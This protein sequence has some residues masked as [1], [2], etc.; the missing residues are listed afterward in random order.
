[1]TRITLFAVLLIVTAPLAALGQAESEAEPH[2]S[3]ATGRPIGRIISGSVVNYTGGGVGGA[4]VIV[5]ALDGASRIIAEVSTNETGDIEVALPD[6]TP[7][8][9]RV[10]IRKDGFSEWTQELDLS[11]E[12]E[13]PFIDATLEGAARLTGTVEIAASGKPVSGA[14][15]SCESGGKD[16]HTSTDADGRFVL[17]QLF[18]GAATITVHAEGF[19]VER[20]V[21]AIK[22]RQEKTRILLRPERLV[23]LTIATSDGNPAAEVAIE[24]LAEPG[25]QH[26]EAV[27]DSRGVARIK[28]VGPEARL[29]RL[30]LNGTRYVRMN[31]FQ[32]TIDVSPAN[33]AAEAGDNHDLEPVRK[34]L[35]VQLAASIRGKIVDTAGEPI[36][37]ARIAAGRRLL[38][39]MP[40]TFTLAD[41]TYELPSLPG[42]PNVLTFLHVDY[43]PQV[44]EIQLHTGQAATI[45]VRMD[46]GK[47]IAGIV[48][49]AK[50]KPTEH[51][52][53]AVDRWKGY[54]KLGMR[55]ITDQEG[56]FAF[57][58]APEGELLLT[59]TDPAT[60]TSVEKT[61]VAGSTNEKIKLEAP[62]VADG[63]TDAAPA[64]RARVP[65]GRQVP[66]L[67][68][69]ATDGTKYK[70]ADL[71]GKF[72]FID[73]W[74]SWCGPCVGEIPN[75]KRLYEATRGRPDFLLIGISL[76][77]DRKA[78]DNAVS[79][80]KMKWPQVFG[81]DSGADEAFDALEGTAIPYTCLIGPDGR[82]IAQHLRGEKLSDEVLKHLAAQAGQ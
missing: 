79:D 1:M 2:E 32:E 53:V 56:R 29:L 37:G 21:V 28:G 51:V 68:M 69:T 35:V 74:A 60:G 41:G 38:Y 33:Q 34:R 62:T 75:I 17:D 9:V 40:M 43:A 67:V 63:G 3:A 27:T 48:V 72:I 52:R 36:S 64:P 77:R 76:D 47:Q 82:M 15:V 18:E 49:G 61:I 50:D 24:A 42:G 4:K 39:G 54:E 46:A 14:E 73:C 20:A 12:S 22:Y 30:R 16:S 7:G 80:F 11:D 66:D 26:F 31:D 55:T 19:A 25:R 10:R 45:D 59:F 13:E 23:E 5:E 57:A 81:P 70:L 58:H 44:Q 78:L 8:K 6:P 71:R 65:D